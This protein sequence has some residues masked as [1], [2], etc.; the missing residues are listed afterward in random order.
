[1]GRRDAKPRISASVTTALTS[2]ATS[3]S[4]GAIVSAVGQ[5]AGKRRVG[6]IGR[7]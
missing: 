5:S 2:A 4:D 3:V 6:S 7:T 1:M